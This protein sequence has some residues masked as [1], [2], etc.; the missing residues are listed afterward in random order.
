MMKNSTNKEGSRAK[1]RK[2]ISIV[3]GRT[4][5]GYVESAGVFKG[6][7]ENG[8]LVDL[9]HAEKS[10]ADN[11]LKVFI[12]AG[13]LEVD[14]TRKGNY[15]SSWVR[16]C[17]PDLPIEEIEERFYKVRTE[18]VRARAATKKWVEESKAKKETILTGEVTNLPEFIEVK[19]QTFDWEDA[20][21]EPTTKEEYAKNLYKGAKRDTIEETL[22]MLLE[23]YKHTKDIPRS[24]HNTFKIEALNENNVTETVDARDMYYP[25]KRRNSILDNQILLKFNIFKEVGNKYQW[26]TRKPDVEMVKELCLERAYQ[27]F[28]NALINENK[29][30]VVAVEPIV[31]KELVKDTEIKN[32]PV[33]IVELKPETY[34][35][36]VKIPDAATLDLINE[37]REYKLAVMENT[38]MNAELKKSTDAN[39]TALEIHT[40][41][42]DKSTAM[43]SHDADTILLGEKKFTECV[44]DLSKVCVDMKA[45]VGTVGQ[46]VEGIAKKNINNNKESLVKGIEEKQNKEK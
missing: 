38:A 35:Q 28:R 20:P 13:L 34:A 42:L 1:N 18:F 33:N 5:N 25:E 9:Y 31:E 45:N 36:V 11:S 6:Y 37:I 27:K 24:S 39:T 12:L 4:I 32:E 43:L 16:W 8:K 17:G 41:A 15:G 22:T 21:V 30:P 26:A 46:I 40:I 44:V 7:D 19:P 3:K 29:K 23:I 14:Q 2:I 10:C